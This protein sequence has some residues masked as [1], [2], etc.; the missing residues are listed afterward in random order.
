VLALMKEAAGRPA[1]ILA[2]PS[3]NALVLGFGESAVELELRFWIADAPNGVQNVKSEALLEM[4]RLFRTHGIPVPRP[5]H[6]VFVHPAAPP[7][8][9]S[10]AVPATTKEPVDLAVAARAGEA[11]LRGRPIRN[12]SPATPPRE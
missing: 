2:E 6:D 1:R 4:W 10:G 11:S 9:R 7:A 5:A 12:H 8:G 3:P